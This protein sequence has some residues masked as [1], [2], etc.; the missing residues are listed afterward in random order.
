MLP[1]RLPLLGLFLS[2]LPALGQPSVWVEEFENGCVQ[3]C[4]ANAY[5]GVNGAWGVSNTGTNGP[6]A[7]R[8][9]ISCQENGNP[10]GTCG[11][12][13][14]NNE[15]LHVG[16][17]GTTC[18]SPNGCFF[19]PAGDCGA[20]YDASCPAAICFVCCS[21]Q[22][23]QTDQRAASPVIDLTGWN[24]LTLRFKYMEGGSGIADNGLLDYFDGLAWSQLADLPKTPAGS[25]GGQGLWTNFSIALPASA[26]NNPN[27]RIGFRW[28]ND[29]DGAGTDPS[30]AI[31]DV[32]ILAP[33]VPPGTGLVVNELSNGASGNKEYIE[34]A[35]V[36]PGCTADIRGMK[37]D[38]NNGVANNGFGTL[39]NGSGVSVG[40]N[41]FAYVAQ[42]ATVPTGSLILIYN[43][44]DL[45]PLVP[46]MDVDDTAPHD[47]I[48]ILPA[49]HA[50]LQGCGAYPDGLVTA[51]YPACGFGAASWT[52][53]GFRDQGDAGQS[54]DAVGRYFHGVSYGPS[55]QNMNN[56]GLDNLLITT[57]GAGASVIWFNTG[58]FRL[59]ANFGFGAIAGN[60]TPGAANNP[61]NLI[62]LRAMR[63]LA[64]PIELVDFSAQPTDNGV[65]L[66]WTTASEINSSHFIIERSA[67]A[68]AF[69]QVGTFPAAHH[70]QQ[71]VRYVHDDPYPPMG[72]LYYRLRMVDL[73]GSERVSPVAVVQRG[74]EAEL[75][76]CPSPDG[77]FNL[78]SNT[79]TGLRWILMDITGRQMGSEH[80]GTRS[81]RPPDGWSL[82]AVEQPSGARR[83][84]RLFRSGNLAVAT[85]VY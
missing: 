23:S 85:A 64:L 14:G 82:L 30:I 42:W 83:V 12:G 79:E 24:T 1:V 21:C 76:L 29:D 28:V 66:A 72:L 53:M 48:Y 57:A 39:M 61:A 43:Q 59:A 13:C 33:Y 68:I 44:A 18:T 51:N 11:G 2:V 75:A 35:V 84:F 37:V 52:W 9:Y 74:P 77:S 8:W 25:C 54:R 46:A 7:N 10:A 78:M 50:L 16:N 56:G 34:L 38:D 15:T 63:C 55:L 71:M 45:N 60:E 36:G 69:E 17:D 65:R 47:S 27:V 6:C 41:R 49:N 81:I 62:W 31:D 67:Q 58:N 70:S 40:H 19:C 73:D 3:N 80:G 32:E 20:A 4:L 26:N 22:S 5:L